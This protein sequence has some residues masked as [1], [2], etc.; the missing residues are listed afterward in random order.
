VLVG[1]T[2]L[3]YHT[4]LNPRGELVA[5]LQEGNVRI[6]LGVAAAFVLGTFVLRM[7]YRRQERRAAG[8]A[9]AAHTSVTSPPAPEV[10]PAV[11]PP[12]EP[13]VT[14]VEPQVLPAAA[15]QTR[16]M[17]AAPVPQ[18]LPALTPQTGPKVAAPAASSTP[19]VLPPV[20]PQPAV[21]TP[22][23]LPAGSQ[24]QVTS[25]SI[26]E[27][28]HCPVCRSSIKLEA[29][30]CRFCG[31]KF[32][33]ARIGYCQ[34][35]HAV[36][37]ADENGRCT[38]CGS[39]VV[40][41]HVRSSLIDQPQPINVPVT[42]APRSPRKSSGVKLVT[43]IA[44]CAALIGACLMIGILARPKISAFLATDTPRPTRTPSPTR[45]QTATPTQTST[46]T[47]TPMPVEVTFDTI[48]DYPTGTRVSMTGVLVFFSSTHCGYEC[49]LLLAEY[50]NSPKKITIFVRVAEAGVDPV[51][52]QMKA[53]PE[54]FGQWDIRVRL[55]NGDYA[56]VGQRI[57]VIGRVTETT[58][59]NPAISDITRIDLTP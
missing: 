11:A 3:F 40:D 34:N 5:A 28:K 49:G 22:V 17:I 41:V 12:A 25:V 58:S 4:L 44:L 19:P 37:D 1:V 20:S 53:L 15:P 45:T 39:A 9:E 56:L 51:P 16:P 35:C 31:A 32:D 48:G 8:L 6:F 47:S 2:F 42:Q 54:N 29:R 46:H 26:N 57:T 23:S 38:G 27:T 52:N 18:A 59:G 13:I 50:L 30:I 33:V 36:R 14:R 7:V 24:A 43:I 10:P 21:A 55:N